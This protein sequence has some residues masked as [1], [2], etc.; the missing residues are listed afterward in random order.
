M[1]HNRCYFFALLVSVMATRAEKS[2]PKVGHGALALA[3]LIG[4]APL[5]ASA[6]LSEKK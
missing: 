4:F 5:D 3:L 6:I 1:R 2:A